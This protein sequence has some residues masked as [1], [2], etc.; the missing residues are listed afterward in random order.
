MQQGTE[1]NEFTQ[2]NAY[3]VLAQLIRMRRRYSKHTSSQ[4]V[5]PYL[6]NLIEVQKDKLRVLAP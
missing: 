3:R 2:Q 1:G 4:W 5:L 6:D